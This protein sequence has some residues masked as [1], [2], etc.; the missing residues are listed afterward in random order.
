M[1]FE[2]ATSTR[3][4]FGPGCADQAAELAADLAAAQ[5]AGAQGDGGARVLIVTGKS[6]ERAARVMDG[7]KKRATDQVTFAVA[8]EPTIDVIARGVE[9]ARSEGCAAVV[10]MGGG[11]A[12][13]AAKAIAALLAN[14]GDAL[15]YLEVVGEGQAIRKRSAPLVAVP[16]TS[17][18][19]SEVTRNAVL[20]VPDRKVKVSM[21]SPLMLPHAAVIDPTLTH[22]MPPAVTAS[23]GLDALTHLIEAYV[24]N[25]ANPITDAFCRDGIRLAAGALSRAYHEGDDADARRDMSLVSLYGGLALANAKLGAVHGFAG[26]LGGMFHAPHGCICGR[27]L[28]HA[29][30]LNV[31]ALESRARDSPSLPRFAEIAA[32]LTGD[33]E[34]T[35][36]DGV[37]WI[38]ALCRDLV[39][40]AMSEY[41]MTEGDIADV[42]ARAAKASSM[43]GNPIALTHDELTELATRAL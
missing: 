39:V 34:A 41:G 18:T 28:P 17:G 32:L 24:S 37:D 31:R 42:V 21:R 30:E 40:P 6:L 43:K 2:F 20:G 38:Q 29:V 4:V 36:G 14:G 16:T 3:I 27:F 8:G 10:A 19:G 9:L 22:S 1:N 12:L 7:L 33:G 5:A 13:D 15:D 26:P 11:S 23:T 35:A 25:K